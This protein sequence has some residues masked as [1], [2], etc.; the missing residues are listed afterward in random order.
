MSLDVDGGYYGPLM[1]PYPLIAGVAA[2]GLSLLAAFIVAT[3]LSLEVDGVP[4]NPWSVFIH[5]G[6][7][8]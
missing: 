3:N 2:P 5:S 6:S 4:S 1:Y 8:F 7:V